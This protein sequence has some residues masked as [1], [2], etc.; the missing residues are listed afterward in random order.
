MQDDE[1]FGFQ[2][3]QWVD[4]H[5]PGLITLGGFSI[6]SPPSQLTS[7]RTFEIAVKRSQHPPAHWVHTQV[8]MQCT[9]TP[10]LSAASTWI[11][12]NCD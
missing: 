1:R 12:T 7:S 6:V 2:P 8:L 10:M 3:G 9:E 4:F 11:A 5:A